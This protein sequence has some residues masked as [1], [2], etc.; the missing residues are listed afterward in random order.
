M[1]L[2]KFEDTVLQSDSGRAYAGI[3]VEALS[4][5][6]PV[7]LYRDAG[8]SEPASQITTNANGLF[9]FWVG[10]GTYTIRYSLGGV[11]LG[12]QAGVEIYNLV[13][14]VDLADEEGAENVGVATG[15]TLQQFLDTLDQASTQKANADALGLTGADNDMGT[16][17]GTIL[18]DN[19]TAKQW[20]QESEAA[21]EAKADAVATAAALAARPITS[22]YSSQ[23]SGRVSFGYGSSG[24]AGVC[25]GANDAFRGRGALV[26]G[27]A[28]PKDRGNGTYLVNDGHPGWISPQCSIKFGPTEFNI[29]G[30]ATGG[31]AT[32]SG[33]NTLTKTEG[34]DWDSSMVGRTLWFRGVAYTVATVPNATTVTL[35]TDPPA[36]TGAWNFPL[37]TGGGTCTVSGTTITRVSGEPFVPVFGGTGFTFRLNGAPVTVTFVDTDT[38]TASIAPG[39]GT[40]TY[41]YFMDI[42]AQI[43][44]LRLQKVAGSSEENIAFFARPDG[45]W[46]SPAATGS[47]ELYPFWMTSNYER[48]LELHATGKYVSLGGIAGKEAARFPFLSGAVNYAEHWGGTAGNRVNMRAR[49]ADTNVGMNFD[50][51]GAGDFIFTSG[52]FGRTN[53]KIYGSAGTDYLA[54]DAVTGAPYLAAE[55]ASANIDIPITPKGTGVV[56]FG[57]WTSNADAAV[58]GYIT[59]KDAAGNTRKLA[60]I[61]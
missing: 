12:S 26:I 19:G 13:K 44:T 61:A 18:S 50:V 29:Y 22:D 46:L 57:T 42:N 52:Q 51:K 7:Q 1:A 31:I 2:A 9:T 3:V 27:G 60:T 32:R 59:I 16:T 33:V 48:V 25:I 40:F 35:T 15:D 28:G 41:D 17:P 45:Y 14:A 49:G 10:E 53:F 5:G 20:F 21:I 38:Y 43:S 34:S 8:G 11:T 39:N 24:A 47:G 54:T 37:T 56:R 4:G 30:N 55:G 23:A 58:N 36:G 6:E